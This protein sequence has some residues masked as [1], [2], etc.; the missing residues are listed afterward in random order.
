MKIL[1]SVLIIALLAIGCS[2]NPSN[3]PVYGSLE[4]QAISS[5][6][7]AQLATMIPENTE[8]ILLNVIEVSVSKVSK[9]GKSDSE[10]ESDSDGWIVVSSTPVTVDFLELSEGIFSQL[11]E[12]SLEVG[13]YNQLR[14]KLGESNEIVIDGVS[15]LLTIPSGTQSGVKLNLNFEIVEDMETEIKIDIRAE[16]SIVDKDGSYLMQPTYKAFIE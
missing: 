5:I 9:V 8:S 6:T 7:S 1:S 14:L 11:S 15:S 4:V 12:V 13:K 2:K 10:E 16:Q 3:S